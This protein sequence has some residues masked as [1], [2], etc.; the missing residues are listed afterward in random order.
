MICTRIQTYSGGSMD[1]LNPDPRDVRSADIAHAL[2]LINRYTG[3]S[4]T[5][6]SVAAHSVHVMRIVP[7]PLRARALLHDAAE[8]YLG[9]WSTILKLTVDTFRGPGENPLRWLATRMQDAIMAAFGFADGAGDYAETEAA[10]KLADRA[11]LT[12][13]HRAIMPPVPAGETRLFWPFV[14]VPEDAPR[15]AIWADAMAA[16]LMFA[17]ALRECGLRAVGDP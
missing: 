16:E 6:Y 9:D 14:D 17:S 1:L 12:L 13:E 7:E 8:A 11:A 15:P 3:H 4:R 10:I 2:S 5:G